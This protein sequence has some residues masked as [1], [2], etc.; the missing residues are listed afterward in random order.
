MAHS[1]ARARLA[2][3]TRRASGRIALTLA[4][5][6]LPAAVRGQ[7][8]PAPAR[9]SAVVELTKRV[10]PCIVASAEQLKL[11]VSGGVAP[12][13]PVKWHH[14]ADRVTIGNPDVRT[15]TCPDLHL[16]LRLDIR[17]D[18]SGG[19]PPIQSSGTMRVGARLTARIVFMASRTGSNVIAAENFR[20]AAACMD[21]V[22]IVSLDT[23]D[24]PT[25]IDST[26]AR[27]RLNDA[28]S[29]VACFDVTSLVLFYLKSGETL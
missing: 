3:R 2:R 14:G 12:F 24:V 15:A 1:V 10:D 17:Y 13:F 26:F 20:Q 29:G 4:M 9:G 22:Q 19:Q 18:R 8:R 7:I 23:R 16:E 5:L 11:L 6:F 28:L 27:D 21:Q 25:W